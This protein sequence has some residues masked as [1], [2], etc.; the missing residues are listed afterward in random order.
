MLFEVEPRDPYLFAGVVIVLL[1][2][3][4]VACRVPACRAAAVDPLE[5]MRTE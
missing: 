4:I 5:A 2:T 3:A 1:A